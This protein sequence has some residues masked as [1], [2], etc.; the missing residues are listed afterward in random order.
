MMQKINRSLFILIILLTSTFTVLGQTFN[1]PYSTFG[2]GDL[3]FKGFARNQAM[4][5][6]SLGMR[7]NKTIDFSNPASYTIR[8]SLSLVFDIGA[9]GKVSRISSSEG[10]NTPFDINF[11]HLAFSF[12]VSRK[13]SFGAG[14]VPY[15]LSNYNFLFRV[16]ENDPVFDPEVGDLDFLFKGEG[17]LSQIFFGLGYEITKNLSFGVNANYTFGDIKRIQTVTLL[18]VPYA[19]HPKIDIQQIVSGFTFNFGLQYAAHLKKDLELVLGA[20]YALQGNLNQ[21]TEFFASNILINP[22]GGQ[23]VDTLS[24]WE[25]GKEKKQ[26]PSGMGFGFTINKADKIIFGVD[27]KRTNWKNSNIM[28]L[29]SLENS[30]S[31]LLGAEYTPNPRELKAYL[32]RIHFRAGAYYTNSFLKIEDY[33]INDFGITFGVGFPIGFSRSSFNIVFD[34][35]K[36]GTTNDNLI[37]E[38]HGS[39]MISLSLY[40]FWFMKR[41]FD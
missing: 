29:D 9:N 4:G 2:L 37:L 19:H 12:P 18:N 22:N 14:L 28:G 36:R 30:Q 6:I 27:Y 40:D 32:P 24:I 39:V 16:D 17:G 15:T 20:T 13:L 3:T 11:S 34:Y 7:N 23:A 26:F 31:F 21:K 38:N 1:S 35:G 25:T 41:K 10:E 8:D 5:G 33:R